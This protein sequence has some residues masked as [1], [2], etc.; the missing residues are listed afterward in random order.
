MPRADK[1]EPLEK[2]FGDLL[3]V[4]GLAAVVAVVLVIVTLLVLVA[5][6]RTLWVH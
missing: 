1:T 5:A 6:A 4:F 3:S 2:A